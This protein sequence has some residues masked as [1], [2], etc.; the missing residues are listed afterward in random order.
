MAAPRISD[1]EWEV[2]NVLWQDTPLTAS[3]IIERLAGQKDW[4]P[5]TVK[6]LLNR[7][8][9]KGALAF[10]QQANRYLYRPKV[11]RE[12]CVRLES[13]SFLSRVFRGQADEMLAHFVKSGQLTPADIE[14]LKQMLSR[15]GR[16]P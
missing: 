6:S 13:R 3:E 7:L 12:E 11:S 10:S 15:K 8:V 9:K 1:A 14:Q 5:R 16:K 2:M 4:S